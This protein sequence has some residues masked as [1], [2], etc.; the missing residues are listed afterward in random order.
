MREAPRTLN[1]VTFWWTGGQ[2][3]PKFPAPCVHALAAQVNKQRKKLV[4][5]S[6]SPKL[7]HRRL[8]EPHILM[9]WWCK[10]EIFAPWNAHLRPALVLDLDTFVIGDLDPFEGLDMS[11]LWLINDFYRPTRGNS[12]LFIAPDNDVLCK[13]VWDGRHQARARFHGDGD[14][15]ETF[16]HSRLQDSIGGLYSYKADQLAFHMKPDARVIC[17]H[18][19]PKPWTLTDGWA[20]EWYREN[21][22]A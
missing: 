4:V 20:A 3:R 9:D 7:A 22:R 12:G 1:Y 10:L 21:E 15:L 6:D 16:K 17:F 19:K 13:R 2:E 5:I 8:E 11:E 18:G 14:Y